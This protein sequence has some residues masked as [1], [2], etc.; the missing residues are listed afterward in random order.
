MSRKMT[1]LAL[2]VAM[3]SVAMPSLA[4]S[5]FAA[6]LAAVP[7][8]PPPQAVLAPDPFAPVAAIVTLPVT[9]AGAIVSRV[10][11]APPPPPVLASY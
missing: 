9:V 1:I 7:P 4:S 8:P 3:S 5:A 2:G 11:P 6:D 10:A